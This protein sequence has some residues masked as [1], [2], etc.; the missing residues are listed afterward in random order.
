MEQIIFNNV[1]SFQDLNLV[2]TEEFELPFVNEN[3]ELIEIEGR[4]GTLTKKLGTYNDLRLTLKLTLLDCEN[5][6]NNVIR[7]A[8]WLTDIEDNRL[9]FSSYNSKCLK[10]K[11]INI[12]NILKD[13][14]DCGT[15]TVEFICNPFYYNVMEHVEPVV[16]GVIFN[17]GDLQCQPVFYLENVSNNISL[18]VNGREL[19]FKDVSGN[20]NINTN[21]YR[22]TDGNGKSLTSKM[23]GNFPFLDKGKNIITSVGIGNIKI[24]KNEIYKG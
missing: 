2:I 8:N 15:F 19:Q 24:L 6:R 5:Y 22:A 3:V 7:I 16:G 1:N 12:G 14:S 13:I 11:K 10:V 17:S 4:S 18:S 20:I 9:I 21:L 23:V